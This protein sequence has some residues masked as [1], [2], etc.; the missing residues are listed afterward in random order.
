M[1]DC[2][3]PTRLGRHGTVWVTANWKKFHKLDLRKTQY[4]QDQKVIMKGCHC[5]ACDKG[6][7]RAYVGHLVKSNEMLG[8]RLA[9]L[10]NLWLINELVKKIRQEI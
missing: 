2:V 5:P 1:F 8:M 6:Y 10:H 3:L 7:S 9:S 4:R